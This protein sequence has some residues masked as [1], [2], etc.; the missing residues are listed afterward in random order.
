MNSPLRM[1]GPPRRIYLLDSLNGDA[2]DLK[3]VTDSEISGFCVNQEL[4]CRF[5]Q[6]RHGLINGKL[7]LSPDTAPGSYGA[8]L[9][10]GNQS[11]DVLIEVE[12]NPKIKTYPKTLSYSGA[13]GEE[14]QGQIQLSNQGNIALV[15]PE[16]AIANL[17][18]PQ[19][20]PTAIADTLQLESETPTELFDNLLVQLKKGYGGLMRFHFNAESSD[21][22]VNQQTVF[23]LKARVPKLAKA[24]HNYFGFMHLER[25]HLVFNLSAL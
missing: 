16:T 19:E 10:N 17:Y 23:T 9:V 21:L 25:F 7:R 8:K 5:R 4:P 13:S 14:I 11:R 22:G 20:I 15:I 24:G 2:G 1:V 12:A 6:K 3:L 18:D